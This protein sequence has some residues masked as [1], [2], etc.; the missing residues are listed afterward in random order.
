MI[1]VILN[2]FQ[3]YIIIDDLQLKKPE[4]F[5]S[6]FFITSFSWLEQYVLSYDK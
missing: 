3:N 4:V 1:N 2:L 6:G 5:T